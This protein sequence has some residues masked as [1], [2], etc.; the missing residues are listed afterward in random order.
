M[1][2]RRAI[3][4]IWSVMPFAICG[5]LLGAAL[6]IKP[7][8]IGKSMDPPVIER[9]D[10]FYGIAMPTPEILWAVGSDGKA[11]RS[12]D[13]GKSWMVQ[14][15]PV[16]H[17]L[18]DIDAWDGLRA[19]AV[20]N[21]GDVI[22]T[23][24]GGKTWKEV[25]APRSEVANKLVRVRVSPDG[26][27]WAVGE[28]GAVLV[29]RDYG[30]TWERA[31]KE[32][33]VGWNDIV[34][35]DSVNGFIVGEF[36]RILRTRD[37]GR[38][39]K[40]AASPVKSS[41]MG[42]FFRDKQHGVAVGMDG[43]VIRTSDSGSTWARARAVAGVHLFDVCSDGKSWLV[44]GDRGVVLT[45][46]ASGAVWKVQRLSENDLSWHT[47]CLTRSGVSYLS[48]STLGMWKDGKWAPFENDARG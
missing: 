14:K 28:M 4:L 40:P 10:S 25:Q 26:S 16:L 17:H 35:T 36:G 18:Q 45:G 46:D 37:G 7:K 30:Q 3:S 34:F 2:M 6:F 22:V 43:V 32:E 29:S 9:R 19:V 23:R 33:D 11:I 12:E 39:W 27:A 48:G 24:D 41:L 5:A 1:S 13:G 21:R 38:T 31:V 15:T 20:G 42:V 8:A 44:V 47:E